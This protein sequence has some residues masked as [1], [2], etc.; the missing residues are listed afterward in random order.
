MALGVITLTTLIKPQECLI[1]LIKALNHAHK[2]PNNNPK[3]SNQ[4]PNNNPNNSDKNPD[5][6]RSTP[7][8]KPNHNPNTPNTK[9]KNNSNNSNNPNNI[10][11]R[12]INLMYLRFRH[13]ISAVPLALQV[14]PSANHS[15]FL[16]KLLCSYL[17]PL[18][19]SFEF[20]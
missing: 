4:N 8:T 16:K 5:N 17:V 3:N 18:G 7:N 15:S 1:S 6:N 11:I 12:I 10:L 2:Y 14:Y 20:P 19:S 9:P 13:A